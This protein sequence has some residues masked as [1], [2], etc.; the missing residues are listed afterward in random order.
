M[1]LICAVIITRTPLRL[2]LG[3]GGTDLRSYSSKYGGFVFTTALDKYVYITVN[4]MFEEMIRLSYSQTEV[5]DAPEQLKHPFVREA[6]KLLGM[7][8]HVE[9]V[10]MADLP[11]NTGLGSSGSFGVGLLHALLAFK[12]EPV[13]LERLA[14]ETC[15]VQMDI[16]GEPEGK[17]DPY[18]AAKGGM[19]SMVID[20]SGKV[21]VSPLEVPEDALRELQKS[22][23]FFYTGIRRPSGSVLSGQ[24]EAV[25]RDDQTVIESLHAIKD[26]GLK[27]R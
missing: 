7:S 11:S 12:G 27:G 21:E 10:S 23:L 14:E 26:S 15:R 4:K 6:L 18:I 24:Q 1:R 16:L 5:V 9:I 3:G 20:R 13:D 22:L 8:K 19:I 2:T 17:Q 25:K